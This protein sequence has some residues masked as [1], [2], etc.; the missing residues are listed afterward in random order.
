MTTGTVK[1]AKADNFIKSL[2]NYLFGAPSRR[3]RT[4]TLNQT[5]LSTLLAAEDVDTTAR[6]QGEEVLVKH[7]KAS[8]MKRQG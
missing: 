1:K 7:F 8:K 5:T 3:T 4:K 2:P 6:V